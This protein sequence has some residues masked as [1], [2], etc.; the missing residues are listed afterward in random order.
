MINLDILFGN[1]DLKVG[2]NLAVGMLGASMNNGIDMRGFNRA[3]EIST[4]SLGY[5]QMGIKAMLSNLTNLPITAS[6]GINRLRGFN[7]PGNNSLTKEE[8]RGGFGI[9]FEARYFLGDNPFKPYV[10][11]YTEIKKF[12]KE[13][14]NTSYT[15]GRSTL[16]TDIEAPA[17]NSLAIG[18]TF[19]FMIS[20][21]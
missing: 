5:Y 3:P 1:E 9:D 12:T 19:G 8:R 13:T 10:S 14:V 4:L 20:Q 18:I 17:L 16:F 2:A 6:L 21:E 11:F 15:S 7:T